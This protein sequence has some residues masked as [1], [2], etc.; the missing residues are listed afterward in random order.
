MVMSQ[1]GRPHMHVVHE[2]P[3]YSDMDH[4]RGPWFATCAE[5]GKA[6]FTH[7]TNGWHDADFVIE[8]EPW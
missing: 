7:Q 5:C 3:D 4:R 6:V 8:E 1:P 2:H